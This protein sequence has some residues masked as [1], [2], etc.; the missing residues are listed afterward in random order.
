MALHQNN[1]AP[2]KAISQSP[3]FLARKLYGL[4]PAWL[5][6]EHA[7]HICL[8]SLRKLEHLEFRKPTLANAVFRFCT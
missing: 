6:S 4:S 8:D 2:R 1:R 7:A 3:V 5:I